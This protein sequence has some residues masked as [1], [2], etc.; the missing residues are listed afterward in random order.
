MNQN[1]ELIVDR[2]LSILKHRPKSLL[3]VKK[4]NRAAQLSEKDEKNQEESKTENI[5]TKTCTIQ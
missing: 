4:T 1:G 5:V 3:V 2:N